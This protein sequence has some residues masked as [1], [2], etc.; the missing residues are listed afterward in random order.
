MCVTAGPCP[1]NADS[2]WETAA[3]VSADWHISV[4]STRCQ[5]ARYSG[6]E[7]RLLA[8]ISVLRKWGL[9]CSKYFL[10]CIF[11]KCCGV[12]YFLTCLINSSFNKRILCV[13]PSGSM[14]K[15]CSS[16]I[17]HHHANAV[18]LLRPLAQAGLRQCSSGTER[19]A[20]LLSPQLL[21]E[22]RRD[23]KTSVSC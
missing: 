7:L 19:S 15:K 10:I 1:P 3:E 17:Q 23:N 21:G 12:C 4:R 13:S 9:I 6:D 14:C 5:T 8:F 16:M 2:T 22:V 11:S 18:R 20:C